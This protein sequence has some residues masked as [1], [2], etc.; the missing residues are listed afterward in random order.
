[1]I[2]EVPEKRRDGKSSFVKL[3]S[4]VTLRDNVEMSET[5]SPEKPFVRKSRSESAIFNDLVGYATRNALPESVDVIA[6]FPDGRQQ[7]RCGDVITETN[8]FS[9]ATAATEMNMVGMQNTRC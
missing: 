6:T 2:A 7:L 3:V 5:L 1:M 8:C 4:Y 9:L